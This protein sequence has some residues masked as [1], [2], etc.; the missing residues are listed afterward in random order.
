MIITAIRSAS[1]PAWLF[2]GISDSAFGLVAVPWLLLVQ[3]A[4]VDIRI[5]MA[6]AIFLVMVAA[7]RPMS[8]RPMEIERSLSLSSCEGAAELQGDRST[9]AS[10]PTERNEPSIEQRVSETLT[11]YHLEIAKRHNLSSRESE[12]FLLL[13]QGRSRPYICEVFCLSDGTV[14]THITHIYRNSMSTIDKLSSTKFRKR[15]RSSTCAMD[16]KA[17]SAKTQTSSRHGR[18]TLSP[19]WQ[20]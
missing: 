10:E 11:K 20:P 13:A 6:V 8:T 4:H 18:Q 15:S 7:I 2:Q 9:S 5:L 1:A 3:E 16:T 12:V 14:K 19:N 17:H